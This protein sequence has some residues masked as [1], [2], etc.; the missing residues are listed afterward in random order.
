MALEPKDRDRLEKLLNMLGSPVDG[1]IANAGRMIQKMAQRYN[2]TPAELCLGNPKPQQSPFGGHQ[3][4]PFA[5]FGFH[6]SGGRAGRAW[7]EEEY[8]RNAEAMER[9]AERDRQRRQEQFHRNREA[10]LRREAER[11]QREQAKKEA[12][13]PRHFPGAYFGLLARLKMIYDAQFEIL[14]NWQLDFIET[15]LESCKADRMMTR[16][17]RDK[18]KAMIK[19]REESEPLV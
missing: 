2:I 16:L 14:E 17:Q 19:A 3:S 12:R 13:R 11:R 9:Q 6:T 18:A 8:R 5:G 1:E 4:D 7:A 15:V 10:T